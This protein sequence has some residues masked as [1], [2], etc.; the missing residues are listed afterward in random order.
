MADLALEKD[1]P[2]VSHRSGGREPDAVIRMVGAYLQ[3]VQEEGMIATLKHFPGDGTDT[4][5]QH[6]TTSAMKLD[7]E[8]WRATQGKVFRELIDQGAMAVM[9]GHIS[10]PAYD[11]PDPRTGLFPP[12]TLSRRILVDLLRDEL[13]FEGLIVTDAINMG[14]VVGFM[15]YFDACASALAAGCDCLLFPRVGRR[16]YDEMLLRVDN[17]MLPLSILQDRAARMLAVKHS[18][19]RYAPESVGMAAVP[20]CAQDMPDCWIRPESAA[21]ADL[22]SA[23]GLTLVRDRQGLVPFDIRPDTRILYVVLQS[24]PSDIPSRMEAAIRKFTD[25]LV[26]LSDPGPDLLFEEVLSERYDLVLCSVLC[27]P[28]YGVNVMRLH[29]PLARNM[30]GGW[31]KLGTPAIFLAHGHPFLHEEYPAAIDTLVNTYGDLPATA[32]QLLDALTGRAELK[33]L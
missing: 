17:G 10:F 7:L 8:T 33:R 23:K 11:E 32:G 31:M 26:M 3:G 2:V 13:G 29:G 6:L 14:G 19:G 21:L 9:P 27:N 15:N 25:R 16:F 28:S 12:A 18:V 22:V 20:A 4:F 24:E 1:S 30:M 5:D